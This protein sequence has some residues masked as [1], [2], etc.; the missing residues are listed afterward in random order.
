MLTKKLKKVLKECR[1]A[2]QPVVLTLAAYVEHVVNYLELAEDGDAKV[3][4]Y[5]NALTGLD[6]SAVAKAHEALAVIEPT[7]E[8]DTGTIPVENS[9]QEEKKAAKK[10]KKKE[11]KKEKLVEEAQTVAAPPI[12][13]EAEKAVESPVQNVNGEKV[14]KAKKSKKKGKLVAN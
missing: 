12:P 7:T 14:K 8:P 6:L 11:A 13:Q 10:A 1:K 4:E 9:G 3:K 2:D 5:G